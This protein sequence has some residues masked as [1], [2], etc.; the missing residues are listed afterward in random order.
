LVK[1]KGVLRFLRL[2]N[3]PSQQDNSYNHSNP[4]ALFPL[5]WVDNP[6]NKIRFTTTKSI[7]ISHFPPRLE[8]R[9]AR[10]YLYWGL[11]ECTTA[12]WILTTTTHLLSLQISYSQAYNL[13][14]HKITAPTSYLTC[15]LWFPSIYNTHNSLFLVFPSCKSCP[16]CSFKFPFT[17]TS[18]LSHSPMLIVLG[19]ILWITMWGDFSH[20]P[21]YMY[22]MIGDLKHSKGKIEG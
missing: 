12:T 18:W 6:R 8:H 14:L 2:T 10:K 20:Q 5:N 22:S 15:P 21:F 16:L 7:T 19:P 9:L 3:L 11:Q 4:L 17:H 13:I 1:E